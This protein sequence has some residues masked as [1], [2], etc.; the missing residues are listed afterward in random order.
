MFRRMKVPHTTIA[1]SQVQLVI[2]DKQLA[3]EVVVSS[4]ARDGGPACATVPIRDGWV[5]TRDAP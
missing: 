5:V 2:D 1:W 4:V 3:L